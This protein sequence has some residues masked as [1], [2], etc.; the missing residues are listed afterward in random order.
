[1]VVD[2]PLQAFVGRA[3]R[4]QGCRD[5]SP[6]LTPTLAAVVFCRVVRRVWQDE[7]TGCVDDELFCMDAD[8]T[9][10]IKGA[11]TDAGGPGESTWLLT[12]QLVDLVRA[13]GCTHTW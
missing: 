8:G 2:R 3:E 1:M 13:P 7:G 9:I 4:T 5:A 6:I 10:S 12:H 11:P